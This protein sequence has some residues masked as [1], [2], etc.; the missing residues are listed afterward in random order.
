MFLHIITTTIYIRL[1]IAMMKKGRFLRK[2]SLILILIT[3]NR[4]RPYKDSIMGVLII[5]QRMEQQSIIIA[6]WTKINNHT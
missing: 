1:R 4:R 3:K 2:L 6:M 5:I